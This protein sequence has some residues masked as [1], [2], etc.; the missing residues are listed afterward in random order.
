MRRAGICP[1]PL[2][3][4]F[5]SANKIPQWKG[6]GY[7]RFTNIGAIL[8]MMGANSTAVMDISPY[9]GADIVADLN[10][11]APD[12]HVGKFD[13]IVD[14]GTIEHVFD[15]SQAFENVCS[16]LKP[17]GSVV[18][19][20]PTS[21]AMDHGFY[22]FSPTLYFD[23]FGANGFKDMRCYLMEGSPYTYGK[24]Q[25]VFQYTEIGVE[26][27]LVSGQSLACL[28]FATRDPNFSGK[29]VTP[30]QCVYRTEQQPA[31]TS[32]LKDILR[33]IRYRVGDYVPYF[34]EKIL[35]TKL[36]KA[37]RGDK[38]LYLGRM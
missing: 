20:H 29:A 17:D 9:E 3:A 8:S 27:S 1:K 25:R 6:T 4:G 26:Y 5:D 31:T 30:I 34:A 37:G 12:E 23:Y 33:T 28:F 24:R 16:L 15:V 7:D 2:P 21:N 14:F 35:Y 11:P 19:H 32:R 18:L 13:V 10:M 22:S 36:F 38:L